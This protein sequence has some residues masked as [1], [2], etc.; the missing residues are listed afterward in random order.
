MVGLGVV[1]GCSD[2]DPA[3]EQVT[4]A[5]AV[6][7]ASMATEVDE[8]IRQ[9][10]AAMLTCRSYEAYRA[11]LMARPGAIGYSADTYIEMRCARVTDRRVRN[12]PT[13]R[14]AAPPTTPPPST[15][16]V[17][18]V[19]E[20]LDGRVIELTPS[21]A[22]PFV[23]EVPAVVQET[24]DIANQ[25]GCEGVLAQRDRWAAEA[26]GDDEASDIASVYAQHAVLVAR[27]I[28]CEGAELGSEPPTSE[29]PTT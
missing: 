16:E 5:S 21:A 3:A 13:C 11:E 7:E 17:A 18:Y 12:S 26:T 2:D 22:V 15:P 20:T 23:G 25:S 27:W 19:A 4:C 1:T 8:Q 9:L 28:G 6:R 24:V 10:D 29:T 14:T